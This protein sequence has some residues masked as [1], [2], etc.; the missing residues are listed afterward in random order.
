[1]PTHQQNSKLPHQVAGAGIECLHSWPWDWMC[2]LHN[3]QAAH[4]RRQPMTRF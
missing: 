2:L 4:P 1:M 3:L